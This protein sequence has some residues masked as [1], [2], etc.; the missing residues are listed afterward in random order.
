[1]VNGGGLIVPA[2]L[3]QP[4]TIPPRTVTVLTTLPGR[5]VYQREPKVGQNCVNA[6]KT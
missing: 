2:A 3:S 6:L 4:T 5:G 1:M